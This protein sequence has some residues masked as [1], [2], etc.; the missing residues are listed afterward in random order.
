[1]STPPGR[2]VVGCWGWGFRDED[3]FN[4][5]RRQQRLKCYVGKDSGCYRDLRYAL[6]FE[7]EAEALAC[8]WEQDRWWMKGDLM[9]L[10]DD[11]PWYWVEELPES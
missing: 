3:E 7:T 10:P 5:E 6:R 8:L 1:M 4:P 11:A 2:F 9:G